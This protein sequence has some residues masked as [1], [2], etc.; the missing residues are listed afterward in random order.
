MEPVSAA[1]AIA[2][3]VS[4]SLA[5][6]D[7]CVRGFV[8]L[9]AAQGFGKEVDQLRAMLDFETWRLYSW[10]NTVGLLRTPPHF[11]LNANT[12]APIAKS[13]LERLGQLLTDTARLKHDYG[14][15]V[16]TTGDEIRDLSKEKG[17]FDRFFNRHQPR[18][19]NDSANVFR[20]RNGPWKKLK[21]VSIDRQ[22]SRMLLGDVKYWVDNLESLLG[23]HE[24]DHNRSWIR[25]TVRT[26]VAETT[27]PSELAAI[28]QAEQS[29]S[30]LGLVAA[31][32]RL[33][34]EG[35]LLNVFEEALT[36]GGE[37]SRTLSQTT[38]NIGS[39][40]SGRR[41]S[42]PGPSH[43]GA[44]MR[45]D[46]NSL[47]LNAN[48]R[49]STNERSYG[50]YDGHAVIVEWKNVEA[51]EEARLK[52]RVD[53]VAALLQKMNHPSFHSMQCIGYLR[54]PATGKYAYLF[55]PPNTKGPKPARL[56]TRSETVPPKFDEMFTLVD[57]FKRPAFRPSLSVRL[58]MA[59][60]LVETIL[61]LHTAGWLH[62]GIRSENIL[63]FGSLNDT[64]SRSGR[65]ADIYLSGYEYARADNLLET[66]EATVLH[67]E[68]LLYKHPLSI[69]AARAVYRKEFDLYSVGCVLLE[70]GLWASLESILLHWVR[71]PSQ[72]DETV[73]PARMTGEALVVHD[74]S[75]QALV[76]ANKE[77]LLRQ[78]RSVSIS[79]ELE[80]MAG[81]RY[82]SVTRAFLQLPDSNTSTDEEAHKD[83]LKLEQEMLTKLEATIL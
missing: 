30:M 69:G 72:V 17:L 40:E 77:A 41:K 20:R 75:E 25:S 70:L 15:D 62:K 56:S 19:V 74:Q 44:A 4:L 49:P 50:T 12:Y 1:S 29:S 14:L 64:V 23:K 5:L 36:K 16:V 83:L 68:A 76:T 21:W 63:V 24:Q 13:I 66:T 53:R 38:L 80:F 2:G 18:F 10:A 9:A 43:S 3:L 79:S 33:R 26:A 58:K 52:H 8:L 55:S 51:R 32:A 7:G 59:V 78:Q 28:T 37:K 65:L 67:N 35:L 47:V 39:K 57:L 22:G 6:L 48:S 81:E 61:Q 31:S 54:D 60:A 11:S 46:F 82:A 45:K 42:P 73:M 27:D 71:T 34:S